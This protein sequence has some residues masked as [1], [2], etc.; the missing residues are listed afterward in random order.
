MNSTIARKPP[1][2]QAPSSTSS[3]AV[4]FCSRIAC[5]GE[6]RAPSQAPS[7]ASAG[8]SRPSAYCVRAP[9][10][11]VAFIEVSADRAT[12]ADT[13]FSPAVPKAARIRSAATAPDL[14]MPAKPRPRR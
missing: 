2:V 4:R 14:A 9:T 5:T 13:S 8:Q 1:P 3:S 6:P 12:R 7:L 11:I 10:I